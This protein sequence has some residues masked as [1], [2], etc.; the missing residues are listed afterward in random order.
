MSLPLDLSTTQ[1]IAAL[2]LDLTFAASVVTPTGATL[3]GAATNHVVASAIVGNVYR[4]VVYSP[5]NAPLSSARLVNVSFVVASGASQQTVPIGI[6]AVVLSSAAAV[7]IPTTALDPGA[8]TVLPPADNSLTISK[9]RTS[10]PSPVTAA[11]QVLGYSVVVTNTGIF[12]QTGITVTDTLPNGSAGGLV[13]PTESIATNG[14]LDVGET[15]TYTISYTVTQANIDSGIALVNTAQVVTTQ[16]PGPTQ[17]TASTQVAQNPARTIVKTQTSGPNPATTAGQSLGYTIVVT[18]TGNVSQT[19]VNVTDTMP[20]G[21]PGVLTGPTQS[22]VPNSILEVGETWT[23]TAGYTVTQ[24]NIMSGVPLVNTARI[25][26]TQVPALTQSA[27]TTQV[28]SVLFANGFEG[29]PTAQLKFATS[30]SFLLAELGF[31]SDPGPKLLLVGLADASRDAFRLELRER[32]TGLE[33]RASVTTLE[34]LRV[35]QWYPV[36][37]TDELMV[38]WW[39]AK[40]GAAD[41]GL[42]VWTNGALLIGVDGA[43]NAGIEVSG[44]RSFGADGVGVNPLQGGQLEFLRVLEAKR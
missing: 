32:S 5:T 6:Q 11:G 12:S 36:K 15:W 17:A 30:L 38:S 16:V 24:T 39:S 23:Y 8:I 33:L 14:V 19:G 9:T 13:G 3:G 43:A 37:R 40:R 21:S 4:I 1:S 41:G 18:N 27:A 10:G 2:Q 42:R 22:G 29:G 35:S 28:G 26:T 31:S 7:S 34:G 25:S 44:L 20:D